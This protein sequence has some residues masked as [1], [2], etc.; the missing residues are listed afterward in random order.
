M[1]NDGTRR[2]TSIGLP[3]DQ[4][5]NKNGENPNSISAVKK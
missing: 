3:T 1:H 2:A 5:K 4:E